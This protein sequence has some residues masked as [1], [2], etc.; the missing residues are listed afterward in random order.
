MTV[1]IFAATYFRFQPTCLQPYLLFL[2]EDDGGLGVV[3][4]LYRRQIVFL[5]RLPS[6]VIFQFLELNNYG[7]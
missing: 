6:K 3:V 4:R 5:L 2:K 7:Q 1:G